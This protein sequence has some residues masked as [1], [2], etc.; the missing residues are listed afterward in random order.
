MRIKNYKIKTRGYTILELVFYISLFAVFTI[1]VIN[2]MI[3]MTRAFR[4]TVVQK[5][6][7]QSGAVIER[8]GREI[9]LANGIN[10]ISLNDLKLNTKDDFD[11]SKTVEFLL[12]GSD[13]QLLENN[14]LTGN[15]NTTNLSITALTFTQVTTAKGTA[16]KIFLTA[17]SNRDQLSRVEDFYDTV[18]LRGNYG[19]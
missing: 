15:L 5:D 10:T 7:I 14:I 13:I 18:V 3:T 12:S 8:I 16:I 4:E 11:A 6:L 19:N 2:S 1:V 17:R 9:R